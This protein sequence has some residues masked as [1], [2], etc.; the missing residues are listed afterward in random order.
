[1]VTI[2]A[3]QRK[4]DG[5]LPPLISWTLATVQ[6]AR[7]PGW[8]IDITERKTALHAS[9]LSRRPVQWE[10]QVIRDISEQ[11]TVRVTQTYLPV[12]ATVIAT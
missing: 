11:Q 1:M 12:L 9:R 4:A 5:A 7:G 8:L 6:M 3:I 2:E 10:G